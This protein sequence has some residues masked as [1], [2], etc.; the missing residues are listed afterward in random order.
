[1]P[2]GKIVSRSSIGKFMFLLCG[3]LGINLAAQA[4]TDNL[5]IVKYVDWD[6]G[7]GVAVVVWNPTPNPINLAN[8]EFRIYG[9]GSN[10]PTTTSQLAGT[11]Q[12][13]ATIM[14]GNDEYKDTNCRNTVSTAN[15]ASFGPGVNGNDIVVL[16]QTNGQIVDAIGR[17]GYDPGNNNS[18]KVSNVNDALYQHKL[19]RAP[20]N[21][22]RY[23]LTSGAYNPNAT[24]TANIWPNNQTT[25]VTGWTVSASVCLTNTWAAATATANAGPDQNRAC[26]SLAPFNLTG[27]VSGNNATVQWSG[28]KGTFSNPNAAITTYTPS[29]QDFHQIKLTLQATSGCRQ[30]IDQVILFNGDSTQSA[31]KLV[32]TPQNPKIGDTVRFTL[33]A[34]NNNAFVLG[35]FNYGDGSATEIK[36]G[37]ASHVYRRAGTFTAKVTPV[38]LVGC[39]ADTLTAKLVI[40]ENKIIE[41]F[42]PNIF[43]PNNDGKNDVY[44][45]QF[46]ATS[47]YELRVVN[48]WGVQ[49]FET[50]DVKK[51][52]D[53]KNCSDGVYFIY[54]KATL[55]TG[56]IIERKLPVTIVR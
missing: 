3:I 54:L 35:E 33:L 16:A 19:E 56:E 2:F 17:I 51:A 30:V 24:N 15:F 39:P 50:T 28:G 49:V 43:T 12:P 8:Y 14:I 45:P 26:K 5:M 21:L 7:S 47:A 9:N 31:A 18:Q 4:Q 34:Q 41:V 42:I 38:S 37:E 25:N 13:C 20:G 10:T 32:I 52:W 23:S 1:M 29:P 44:N 22:A 11:L 36:R 6:S 55:T 46:P 53:G 27:V 48:R 40:P